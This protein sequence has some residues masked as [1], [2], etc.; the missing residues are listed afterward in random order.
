MQF[1]TRKD[2]RSVPGTRGY[3][4]TYPDTYFWQTAERVGLPIG[5]RI[6]KPIPIQLFWL[7]EAFRLWSKMYGYPVRGYLQQ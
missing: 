7:F 4:G 1:W 3:P 5:I 6:T 2:S